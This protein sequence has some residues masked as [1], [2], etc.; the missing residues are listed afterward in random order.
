MA[1][2]TAISWTDH[3]RS[4]WIGCYKKSAGC[5]NC[6]AEWFATNR[7]G[8]RGNKA[9]EGG[10]PYLWTP[11]RS[12]SPPPPR[13][14]TS[15]GFY[16]DM[17]K[18]NAAAVANG[19]LRRVFVNQMADTFEDHPETNRLRPVLWDSVREHRNL[20]HLVLTKEPENAGRMIPADVLGSPNLWLGVSAED[21]FTFELRVPL[22]VSVPA[23]VHFVS[24]EPLLG[25]L[26]IRSWSGRRPWSEMPDRRLWS[27]AVRDRVRENRLDKCDERSVQPF[28]WIIIGGESKQGANHRPRPFEIE[29]V[30]AIVDDRPWSEPHRRYLPAVH[31]KQ[32]GDAAT[33]RG[34]PIRVTNGGENPEQWPESC[35]AFPRA[36]PVGQG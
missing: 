36:F 22:I 21:Q 24:A 17:R 2:T 35:R 5:A 14:D 3:S 26:S 8:Y 25:P 15:E 27:D 33:Y 9:D 34:E 30:R 19:E 32:T 1:E 10:K 18:W 13:L 4:V 16:R 20:V 29:W 7:M 31:F 28:D 23:V 6:W 12:G 11:A